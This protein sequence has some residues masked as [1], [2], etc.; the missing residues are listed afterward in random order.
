MNKFTIELTSFLEMEF[1]LG[2]DPLQIEHIV[3]LALASSA[4]R[5]A[6][7]L[8]AYL[9]I[10]GFDWLATMA[11]VSGEI[12]NGTWD[13]ALLLVTAYLLRHGFM[14]WQVCFGSGCSFW[15]VVLRLCVFD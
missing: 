12:A 10:D 3:N 1:D 2:F 7:C 9:C 11:G 13:G 6:V 14:Y 4:S 5:L 8:A 15:F